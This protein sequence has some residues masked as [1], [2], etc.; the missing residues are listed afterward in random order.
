M[1]FYYANPAWWYF[2]LILQLYIV[3]PLLFRLL[4]RAGPG[5]FLILCG[6]ET[7]LSRYILLEVYPVSGDYV[8]G[9]FFGCRLW[10]FAFGMVLGMW[11]RLDRATLERRLF[12]GASIPVAL[13][14]YAVGLHT[15]GSLTA[16][17]LT[18]ALTSTGMFLLMA[19]VSRGLDRAPRTAATVDY[20]GSYSYGLYLIH[21]PYVI[22]FGSR[23]RWLNLPEFT[24]LA[25]VFI[26]IIAAGSIYLEK[27]VNALT[28]RAFGRRKHAVEPLEA[29]SG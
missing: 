27:F 9:G 15:Y 24:M 3:F 5:W 7:I 14:I 25:A 16:Y 22:Y 4:Q 13:A 8:Q 18:D 17:T 12:G 23:L 29:A 2:S 28:E 6:L 11:L 26:A 1:I 20:V 10:E 21:Q 19:H